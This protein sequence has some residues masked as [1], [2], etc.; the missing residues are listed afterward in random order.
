MRFP[1]IV[2]WLLHAAVALSSP[3]ETKDW[4]LSVGIGNS[5]GIGTFVAD[6]NQMPSLTTSII[7]NPSYKLNS[8]WGMP[9]LTLSAYQ[10]MGVWWLDSYYTTANNV[11]NRFF[12]WDTILSASMP[13]ILDFKDLGFSVGAGLG[14]WLPASSFSRKVNRILAFNPSLPI[15]WSKWGF[16]AG[17]TPSALIW[18]HSKSFFSVPCQE[19]PTNLINPYDANSNL[20]QALQGLS[21]NRDSSERMGNGQCLVSGRQNIWTLYNSFSLGWSNPNHAVNLSLT[22]VLNFLR[23]LSEQPN[24]KSE[25]ASSNN[26]NEMTMG[27]IAYSYTLPV[28]TDLT[29]AITAGVL[30]MQSAY[31]D[32]GRL[33]FP[34]FDF[35]SPNKNQTQIFVQATVGI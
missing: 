5:V 7:L 27:R 30:S 17:Y 21:L 13:K 15:A 19:M 22:W 34:F 24:L 6:Y 1:K 33:T 11:D 20:D 25:Y 4:A 9:R 31:D 28:E 35:V 8:F 18:T 14:I 12:L 29:W 2:F 32:S 10:Y 23:P 3:K 16:S 26:F